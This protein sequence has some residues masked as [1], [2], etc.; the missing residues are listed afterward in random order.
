MTLLTR[1]PAQVE[2]QSL[3]LGGAPDQSRRTVVGDA[4]IDAAWRGAWRRRP[5][6][7]GAVSRELAGFQALGGSHSGAPLAQAV[8]QGESILGGY[9]KVLGARK[10]TAQPDR[11]AEQKQRLYDTF[12]LQGGKKAQLYDAATHDQELDKYSRVLSFSDKLPA[13]A[14]NGPA[15]K[16]IK[17]SKDELNSYSS[18]LDFSTP[19]P[20]FKKTKAVSSHEGILSFPG[21]SRDSAHI[22]SR[23]ANH[24]V[25]QPAAMA[26]AHDSYTGILTFPGDE[27]D[28]AR[29]A[30]RE[31]SRASEHG[32]PA[33]SHHTAQGQ[34]GAHAPAREPAA[35]TLQPQLMSRELSSYDDILEFPGQRELSKLAHPRHSSSELKAYS[36]ILDFGGHAG[37]AA[38]GGNAPNPQTVAAGARG[39]QRTLALAPSS[40]IKVKAQQQ[41]QQQQ[42]QPGAAT[43]KAQKAA[44]V[45]GGRAAAARVADTGAQEKGA[46]TMLLDEELVR[47]AAAREVE[48]ERAGRA[49]EKSGKSKAQTQRS[50]SKAILIEPPTAAASSSPIAKKLAALYDEAKTLISE[51]TRTGDTAPAAP[52][53][54]A[55]PSKARPAPDTSPAMAPADSGSR[56]A[57]RVPDVAASEERAVRVRARRL[58]RDPV[59]RRLQVCSMRV[60][61]CGFGGGGGEGSAGGSGWRAREFSVVE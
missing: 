56:S 27:Q 44:G 8:K 57:R 50:E 1:E 52:A 33:G 7:Y 25:L 18:I 29:K 55:A 32:A 14:I 17:S 43:A 11:A 46:P 36:G 61:R 3:A 5:A 59:L 26:A 38:H 16:A 40:G 51:E 35:H 21:S 60:P 19:L 4:N 2:E 48:N 10:A 9:A 31:A 12:I 54:A 22:K 41:Q 28:T 45:A 49:G 15:G 37:A 24:H 20:D 23:E 6:A 39:D 58:S 47:E 13:K 53:A 30:A 34:H 42:Q